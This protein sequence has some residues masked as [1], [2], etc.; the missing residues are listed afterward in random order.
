MLLLSK[1]SI[2]SSSLR[3][4]GAI[5]GTIALTLIAIGGALFV[6]STRHAIQSS[7]PRAGQGQPAASEVSVPTTQWMIPDADYLKHYPPA[8]APAIPANTKVTQIQD[9]AASKRLL[10]LT[11]GSGV[12]ATKLAALPHQLADMSASDTP[13]L[14]TVAFTFPDG[15]V[16]SASQQQLVKPLP[17]SAM[18]VVTSDQITVAANGT[19]TTIVS[20]NS[21][22]QIISVTRSG[23]MTQITARGVFAKKIDPPLTAAE[24]RTMSSAIDN[25]VANDK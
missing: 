11:L 3:G 14:A 24:L 18:H 16:V 25:K 10:A 19:M 5:V 9:G 8:P 12:A 6:V 21:M 17:Y 13:T 20:G 2:G 15:S 7:Q 1:R 22:I 4:I 23:L